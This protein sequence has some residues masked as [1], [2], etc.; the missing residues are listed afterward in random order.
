MVAVLV[1]V[2]NQ[3]LDTPIPRCGVGIKTAISEKLLR[4]TL[5][6]RLTVTERGKGMLEISGL[7]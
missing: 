3:D 7:R 1:A 4:H 6:K 5:D 2:H